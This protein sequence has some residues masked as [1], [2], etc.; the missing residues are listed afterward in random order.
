MELSIIIGTA[1]TTLIVY[2]FGYAFGS[3]IKES[4]QEAMLL[5]RDMKEEGREHAELKEHLGY[6]YENTFVEL[7]SEIDLL[8]DFDDINNFKTNCI[9]LIRNAE[10]INKYGYRIWK[11]K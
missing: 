10:E 11:N 2:I 1:I 9:E 3:N 6:L 8:T 4:N 5:M 7:L